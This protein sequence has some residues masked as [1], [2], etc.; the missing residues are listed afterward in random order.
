MS[1]VSPLK[2]AAGWCIPALLLAFPAVLPAQDSLVT[3]RAKGSKTAPV[4]IFEMGDFQCPVCRRFEAE[5]MPIIDKEYIATGKVY[6]V[7]I[8]Y[9]LSSIH[10]NAEPAAEFA[11]CAAK[12]GKFWPTHDLLYAKQDSWARLKDPTPFLTAQIEPLGLKREGMMDCLKSGAGRAV[13]K[14]D[15]MV[16]ARTGATGTPA[17]YIEGGLMTGYYPVATMRA[18]IDSVYK[19]RTAKKP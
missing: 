18:V 17:F 13:V 3:P 16:S 9:P 15:A 2:R 5:A 1:S 11:A 14:E 19:A 6:W 7:F 10:P 4:T 8:H 12:Q